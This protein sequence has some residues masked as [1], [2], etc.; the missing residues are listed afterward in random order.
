MILEYYIPACV[1]FRLEYIGTSSTYVA[2]FA[3][4]P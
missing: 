3:Y 2:R 1:R 4:I